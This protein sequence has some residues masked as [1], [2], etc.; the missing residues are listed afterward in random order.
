MATV[1]HSP[2]LFCAHIENAAVNPS[3][4]SVVVPPCVPIRNTRAGICLGSLV[5]ST[6]PVG[7]APGSSAPRP[8]GAGAGPASGGA[9]FCAPAAGRAFRCGQ[10][11]AN[12]AAGK[13]DKDAN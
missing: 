13:D 5:L 6:N 4:V 1:F 7:P 2:P 10:R 3:R 9:S 8:E 11:C 12:P